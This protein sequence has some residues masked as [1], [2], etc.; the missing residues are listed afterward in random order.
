MVETLASN[1]SVLLKIEYVCGRYS[2]TR[3]D[4]GATSL[5]TIT[6]SGRQDSALFTCM[7]TN[8]YGN[9][10]T[11]IQLRCTGTPEALH[12]T[13][14]HQNKIDM[15]PEL[16]TPKIEDIATAVIEMYGDT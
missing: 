8:T 3:T 6:G 16:Y 9:D 7:A 14:Q 4:D 5:L 11:N 10:E 15:D 2:V 12:W 13:R 1:V